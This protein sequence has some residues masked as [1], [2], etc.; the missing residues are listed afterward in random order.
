MQA[1][2]LSGAKVEIATLQ[3]EIIDKAPVAD[4][5]IKFIKLEYKSIEEAKRR[6]AVLYLKTLDHRTGSYV[7]LFN[8]K[9]LAHPFLMSKL[10]KIWQLRNINPTDLCP[11]LDILA[12]ALNPIEEAFK[13]PTLPP[14][15][16]PNP[17]PEEIESPLKTNDVIA[18]DISEPSQLSNHISN[19]ELIKQRVKFAREEMQRRHAEIKI[20][21][22]ME[23]EI[24]MDVFREAREHT[25][26]IFTFRKNIEEKEQELKRSLIEAQA[27]KKQ[28]HQN[29]K[30]FIMQFA[31]AK[32]MIGKLMKISDVDRYKNQLQQ[33]I[34]DK[35]T[36]FKQNNK[37]RRELVQAILF[38]KFKSS[39]RF[40]L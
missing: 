10:R 34:K 8:K 37:E 39:K 17:P 13:L 4:S 38:E 14:E 20:S 26:E 23:L 19:K 27:R 2:V 30:L 33:E 24:K 36:N 16:V 18:D 6:A 22:Q 25:I 7:P 40:T 12:K 1:V 3:S 11:A 5:K 9:M 15:Q 35:V 32:N 28:I 21:K 29:E 31:Q